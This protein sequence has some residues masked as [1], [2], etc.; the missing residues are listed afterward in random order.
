MTQRS[1]TADVL[2]G[3]AVV[4]M[5]QVHI[6][7]LFATPEILASVIGQF[8]LFLGG[9]LVAPIFVFFLGYF[10]SSSKKTTVQLIVRGVKI[11]LAGML[12]N[13]ALNFNL[14]LHICLGKINLDPLPYIFGVDI[15]QLAGISII[16][17]A[18]L[19]KLLNKSLFITLA[20]SLLTGYLGSYL[21]TYSTDNAYIQY[22]LSYFYG[23]SYWSY[24][25]IFPW[26]SYAL[27]GYA[28]Y[29]LNQKHNL[30]TQFPSSLK[31]ISGIVF[32][33]FLALSLDYAISVSSDLQTYYHHGFEFFIWTLFFMVLYSLTIHELTQILGD[34]IVFKYL[35]W[36]GKNVTVI[37]I[38]QWILIGNIATFIFKSIA[39][40]L[41][42]GLSFLGILISVSI[43]T[44]GYLKLKSK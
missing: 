35:K 18:L 11:F 39:S 9:P 40:P 21:L 33:T 15:L 28:F 23:I 26:I 42:L 32:I 6:V 17:I 8:L 34:T 38:I 1:Q 24:F 14:L 19:K 22:V 37:Y 30:Q 3:I 10:V 20:I 12:L 27:L 16:L 13:L 7:E 43:L 31:I 29:Q 2:K 4:L 41:I 36:L 44:I 5:I 25:P